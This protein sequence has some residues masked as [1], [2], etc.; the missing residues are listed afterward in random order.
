MK[1][2]LTMKEA[3]QFRITE[4]EDTYWIE[5]YWQKA[6]NIF[7]ANILETIDFILNEC[8][9]EEFYWLSEIFEEIAEKTQSKVFIKTL[10]ER[11]SKVVGENYH[12][13]DFQ[14]EHMRKYI[15]YDEYIRDISQEIEYAEGRIGDDKK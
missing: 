8:S 4:R 9:D 1:E 11:L 15:T 10:R 14:T 5:D 12:Q 2:F 13:Q 7:T 6:I 3:T